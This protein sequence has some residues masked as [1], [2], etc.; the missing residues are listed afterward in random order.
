[1]KRKIIPL[2]CAVALVIL[3]G[4]SSFDGGRICLKSPI[5]GEFCVDLPSRTRATTNHPPETP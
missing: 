3:S 1:M 5:G 4:C 2:A